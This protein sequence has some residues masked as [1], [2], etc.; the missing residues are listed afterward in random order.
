M[1]ELYMIKGLNLLY[2][3]VSN[4]NIKI[5]VVIIFQYVKKIKCKI[6]K[7]KYNKFF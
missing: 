4:K 2:D 3:L 5:I 1:E 7:I 6:P